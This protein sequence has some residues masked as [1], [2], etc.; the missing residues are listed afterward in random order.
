MTKGQL[1]L[2]CGCTSATF[3]E[4]G[5]IP[6][7]DKTRTYDPLPHADMAQVVR[8]VVTDRNPGFT[9]EDWQFG[10][11]HDGNRMFGV[12]RFRDPAVPTIG[13]AVGMRNSYDR[14]FSAAL[15]LGGQVFVCDNMCFSGEL[16][17]MTRHMDNP[18][19]T[20]RRQLLGYYSEHGNSHWGNLIESATCMEQLPCSQVDGY[21][22]VGQALGQQIMTATVA[23]A[24]LNEWTTPSFDD[25]TNRNL[26]SLYNA[27]T[28]ALKRTPINVQFEMQKAWHSFC[29]Q[30]AR[31][32]LGGWFK[33]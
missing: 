1:L 2:H 9:F 26:W 8:D 6:L 31:G 20:L 23:N 33:T 25:F 17:M 24:C 30:E 11:S 10:I 14:R 4:L 16:M 21:R 19:I 7:P 22:M 15:A 5:K 28:L 32:F 29:T 27:G 3:E 12:C 18:I 13:Y